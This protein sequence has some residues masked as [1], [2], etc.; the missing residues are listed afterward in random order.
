MTRLGLH[1]GACLVVV[2]VSCGSPADTSSIDSAEH[3]RE[4]LAWRQTRVETLRAPYGWLSLVGL[5]WLDEGENKFG[6]GAGNDIV[7]P[8]SAAAGR[9]GSI[10]LRSGSVRVEAIEGIGLSADD[11]PVTSMV[12]R[13]DIDAAPTELT[14]GSVRFHIIE[15]DHKQAVRVKDSSAKTRTEFKGID[16]YPIDSGGR[17]TARFEPYDPPK[18][19]RIV[20]VLGMPEPS[21]SPG[22]LMF[23]VDGKTFRLDPIREGDSLFVVFGD[24][25]NGSETYGGG[26]FVYTD[27]PSADGTVIVDF[28]KSYNPPC[29][30]TEYSTCPLPPEQNKL[31][32]PVRAG[33]KVY[34]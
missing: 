32:M 11:E 23:E 30:F 33:E 2:F 34:K 9:A 8:A 4:I 10:W 13:T 28:N 12:L 31:P 17:L 22:A 27:L 16:Y 19:L 1:L 14:L 21:E 6:S 26:R 15:R 20:S 24:A 3:E 18:M 25:T 5:H 29:V 7:L